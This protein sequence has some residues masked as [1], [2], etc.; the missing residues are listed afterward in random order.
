MFNLPAII[1]LHF[2]LLHFLVLGWNS[3][4]MRKKTTATKIFGENVQCNIHS[5]WLH[6]LLAHRSETGCQPSYEF[7]WI[8]KRQRKEHC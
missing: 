6:F 3:F 5:V 1:K 7:D 2:A 8:K 4:E